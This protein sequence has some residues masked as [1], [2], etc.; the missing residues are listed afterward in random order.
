MT[1]L[2]DVLSEAAFA[3]AAERSIPL[4]R[5]TVPRPGDVLDYLA[6]RVMDASPENREAIFLGFMKPYLQSETATERWLKI[7]AIATAFD[8][9]FTRLVRY[10]EANGLPTRHRRPLKRS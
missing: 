9:D 8:G 4:F 10:F 1:T 3:R 6:R 5:G 2:F 7:N